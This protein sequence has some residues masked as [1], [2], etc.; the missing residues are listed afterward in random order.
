M[1]YKI[2][3]VVPSHFEPGI[4]AGAYIASICGCLLTVEW[5]HRR[6]TGL[7]NIRSWCD[8]RSEI[9]ANNRS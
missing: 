9:C 6:V 7:Q 2:G 1:E 4:V 3:D 5:L 8:C